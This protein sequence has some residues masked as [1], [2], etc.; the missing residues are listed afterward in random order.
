MNLLTGKTA[1]ITGASKGI[2]KKIAELF[3][4]QGANVAF[5]YLS[6]VEKG[7]ALAKE[8]SATGANVK[9]YRS[10]ASD[11]NAA[12]QL[13]NDIVA[14]FGRA[15]TT[16]LSFIGKLIIFPFSSKLK[17]PVISF[18]PTLPAPKENFA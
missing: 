16:Y 3:A 1:L 4:A 10:D 5:T 8:L 14:D 13:I 17:D 7:E 2:G 11:F 9:G 6:S 12:E 18:S 15:T